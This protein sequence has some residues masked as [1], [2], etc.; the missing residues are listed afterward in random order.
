MRNISLGLLVAVVCLSMIACA[1]GHARRTASILKAQVSSYDKDF[2]AVKA[3]ETKYYNDTA[4]D[5]Q[6]TSKTF[7][8]VDLLNLRAASAYAFADRLAEDPF[9][10]LTQTGVMNFLIESN[11]RE[12]DLVEQQRAREQA[13]KI[14]YFAQLEEF[15]K[16]SLDIGTVQKL[17]SSLSVKQ[18][19]MDA[20]KMLADLIQNAK[21]DLDKLTKNREVKP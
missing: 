5:M 8:G 11:Q 12:F 6:E 16:R 1:V 18:Q 2:E 14:D 20:A 3:A 13:M 9:R 21:T 4:G 10:N 15:D 7:F 19:P 17:L